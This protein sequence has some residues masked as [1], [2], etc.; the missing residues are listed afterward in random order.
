MKID[1][2]KDSVT[3][4]GFSHDGSLCACADMSGVIRVYKV[5]AKELVWEFETSDIT[6]MSWHPSTNV[7]FVATTDSELWLWKLPSGAGSKVLPGHGPEA[8]TGCILPDGRRAAV[9]Y[10]DGQVRVFDLKTEEVSQVRTKRLDKEY[11]K[12][13]S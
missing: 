6:W 13:Q 9:G 1:G 3:Q 4:V 7:L 8:E 5:A 12:N 2:F 10:R 11:T